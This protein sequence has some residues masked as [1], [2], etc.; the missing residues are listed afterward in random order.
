MPSTSKIASHPS[1]QI[2]N[3]TSRA[4]TPL[5]SELEV[6]AMMEKY[7][8]QLKE[9]FDEQ[10]GSENATAKLFTEMRQLMKHKTLKMEKCFAKV[11]ELQAERSNLHHI[12]AK[13]ADATLEMTTGETA[14]L[15][16]C[17]HVR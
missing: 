6:A 3:A 9:L 14:H 5:R 7:E 11:N 13:I 4:Q 1:F 16:R 10:V 15:L 8:K 12:N 2:L 17:I